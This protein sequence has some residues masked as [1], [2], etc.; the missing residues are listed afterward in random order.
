MKR[1]KPEVTVSVTMNVERVV[2]YLLLF[3]LS[4]LHR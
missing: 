4:L 1:R 2:L 3:A